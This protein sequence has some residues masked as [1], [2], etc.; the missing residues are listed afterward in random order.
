MP[1][2]EVIAAVGQPFPGLRPFDVD[3]SLLFF[4]RESHVEQLLRSLGNSRFLAVIGSSGSGKSSLVRAG[5]LPA[6]YRGYL[7][8]STTRW[9]IAVMRPGAAPLANLCQALSA[10]AALGPGDEARRLEL[11]SS[12]SLGLVDAVEDAGLA[13]GES[14]LVVV[15]QFEE[16]FRYR[17]QAYRDDGGAEAALFVSMLLAAAD[18]FGAPVY[19]VLTMRSDFLGECTEF[20]GLAETLSRS[21]YLIP[22]LTREQRRQAIEKP[23]RLAGAGI[24]TRCLQQVLNDWGDEATT[25]PLPLLQ[26][27][28]ARTFERWKESGG[29]QRDLDLADYEA[30]KGMQGAL[31]A[32][33]AAIFAALDDTGKLWAQ[34]IF[35]ALTATELGRRIRRPTRLERLYQIVGATDLERGA[36]DAVLSEFL[37][38]SLLVASPPGALGPETVLDIP[39]ESLITKWKRLDGWT[40]REAANAERYN[41]AANGAVQFANG[42]GALWRDPT[43]A[44]AL[45]FAKSEGWNADWAAQYRPDGNP[46][47]TEVQ[48][49]LKRS[50]R[51]QRRQRVLWLTGVA[52]LIATIA[53]AGVLYNRGRRIEQSNRALRN[54]VTQ[55]QAAQAAEVS[56]I[57]D[58]QKQLQQLSSDKT[59]TA[60]ERAQKEQA[61]QAQLASSQAEASRLKNQQD[62]AAKLLNDKTTDLAAANGALRDRLTKTEARLDA[63]EK[64]RQDAVSQTRTL[65]EKLDAANKEVGTLRAAAS[66]VEPPRR[67]RLRNRSRRRSHLRSSSQ[68][69]LRRPAFE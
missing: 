3:D 36:V 41:D 4:G 55:I 25:D 12:S 57:Q 37:A 64:Q 34:K 69:R 27:A 1:L 59:L 56:K 20:P 65:K 6:L 32:H 29:G 54:Q 62:Q 13:P 17:R 23:L 24:A 30:A 48:G 46:S 45:S 9:R 8:G 7:A 38:N 33:A 40:R 63:T 50:R 11:L 39:H 51:A 67:M 2:T 22:R 58:Y 42:Q 44:T 68:R 31:N 43:L 35:R 53:L 5:L 19:I 61:L 16:L 26:H 47:F 49:F 10:A 15:D 60:A 52:L 18:Q 21:Q 66:R 28:L 14:V